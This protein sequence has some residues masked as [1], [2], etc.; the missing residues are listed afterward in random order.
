MSE[1]KKDME[2]DDIYEGL[3]GFFPEEY[4]LTPEELL[5]GIEDSDL[6]LTESTPAP[7]LRNENSKAEDEDAFLSDTEEVFEEG[8]ALSADIT[9]AEETDDEAPVITNEQASPEEKTNK[10]KKSDLLA[11]I[12][13]II[14]MFAV[15]TAVIIIFFSFFAR[16]T[17][18]DGDS[19]NNTL[20]NGE[21]LLITNFSYEPVRG[22]IVVVQDNSLENDALKKPL[23]KR[24]I[25]TGGE[26]VN[27]SA[28]G[29]VTITT[30][31]GSSFTL[32]EDYAYFEGGYSKVPEG[33]YEIPEGY[34][35]VMGDNRNGS[36]DSRFSS[37]GAI[38]ERCIVGKA[39]V[40]LLPIGQFSALTNPFN[41]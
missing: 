30:A 10:K 13:D 24:I 25:A 38:D 39:F 37:V 9:H 41:K 14:E 19:M 8:Y 21:T 27:V 3:K 1:N 31:D 5:S 28:A 16:L 6:I 15:C 26:T 7:D 22:D 18:V 36:T 35:F 11:D 12:Y 34:I 23:I 2:Q 4:D 29:I 40:R 17:V 20:K 33:H 32:S